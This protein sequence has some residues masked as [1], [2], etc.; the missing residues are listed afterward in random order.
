MEGRRGRRVAGWDLSWLVMSWF[1][2]PG[3][4]QERNALTPFGLGWGV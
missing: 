4:T 1:E 3:D 2:L